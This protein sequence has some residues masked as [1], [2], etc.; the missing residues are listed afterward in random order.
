MKIKLQL[1]SLGLVLL[2]GACGGGADR[3]VGSGV[4]SARSASPLP[5]PVS[6][7][8]DTSAPV[9]AAQGTD[10]AKEFAAATQAA[11]ATSTDPYGGVNAVDAINQLFAF[12]AKTFPQYFPQS[13]ALLRSD[14]FDYS[15]FP[16]TS[17]YLGVAH[18][19]GSGGSFTEGGV[20][21][22]GGPFGSGP[23]YVGQLTQFISPATYVGG[24]ALA[25][26]YTELDTARWHCGFGLLAQSPQ[27]DTAAAAH[28][29]YMAMNS[30]YSHSETAG[31]PG[32]TGASVWE[33]EAAA[34]Y[35]LGFPAETIAAAPTGGTGGDAVRS[36]LAVPY[37]AMGLI[38]GYRDV[39]LGWSTV[40]GF[41]TLTVDMA[42]RAG[43]VNQQPAGVATYPCAG[44]VDAIAVAPGES[45]SPF[46]SN[47]TATWGQPITVRGP[48]DLAIRSASITGPSGAVQILAI[49]GDGQTVD[50]NYNNTFFTQGKAVIIPA[51]LV[52]GT[53][54]SVT[55]AYIAAGASGQ[56]NFTFTTGSR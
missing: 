24:S 56:S 41:G 42:T 16:S 18:N 36:L 46:P 9:S 5:I 31:M 26:A 20:Y 12:A 21:V 50:P 52:P 2:L 43:Q 32:F 49:Y 15:Y 30:I 17:V 53:T 11:V 23:T 55:I 10:A 48:V 1:A 6:A 37:H 28:S 27:I 34:G 22:M 8:S 54:Y 47:P 29:A 38:D 25:D 44:I 35:P 14:P 51:P 7:P 45:P 3:D 33:R 4:P 19:V 39:G 40:N 13:Q